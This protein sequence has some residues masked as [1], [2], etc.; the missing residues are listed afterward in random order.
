MS[1]LQLKNSSDGSDQKS[2]EPQNL[3]PR[4]DKRGQL[5]MTTR[6]RTLRR[7]PSP[8]DPL[9]AVFKLVKGKAGYHQGEVCSQEGFAPPNTVVSVIHA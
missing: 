9:H 7:I 5:E 4:A 1:I 2:P 6:N 8:A 3:S